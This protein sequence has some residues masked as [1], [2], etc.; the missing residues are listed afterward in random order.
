MIREILLFLFMIL[1]VLVYYDKSDEYYL[2]G[3]YE[4]FLC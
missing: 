4:E 2:K 1:F 3:G